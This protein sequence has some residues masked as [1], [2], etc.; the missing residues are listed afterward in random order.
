MRRPV[1]SPVWMTCEDEFGRTLSLCSWV[2]GEFW[3]GRTSSLPAWM[4]G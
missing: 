2:M 1:P 4:T 3:W